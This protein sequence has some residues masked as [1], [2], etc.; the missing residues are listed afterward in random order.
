MLTNGN[1]L[2]IWTGYIGKVVCRVTI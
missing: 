1:K 2:H